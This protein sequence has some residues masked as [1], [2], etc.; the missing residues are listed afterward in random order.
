[1]KVLLLQAFVALAMLG[2]VFAIH[3]FSCNSA[4]D[5]RCGEPFKPYVQGIVNCDDEVFATNETMKATICR[6]LQQTSKR[7]LTDELI[8]ELNSHKI[9]PFQVYG[10][11]RVT[12]SCGFILPTVERKKKRCLRSTYVPASESLY[13][14]CKEDLCNVASRDSQRFGLLVIIGAVFVVR[15]MLE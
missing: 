11:V 14:D 15:Q 9:Y 12:R 4:K 13:C 1:M 6:K 3:C 5:A 10:Q 8:Q 7:R 2:N